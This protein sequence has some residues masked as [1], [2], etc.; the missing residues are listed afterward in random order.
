MEVT[1]RDFLIH[2]VNKNIRVATVGLILEGADEARVGV[3]EIAC[4]LVVVAHVNGVDEHIVAVGRSESVHPDI[5]V[6]KGE[7]AIG[8]FPAIPPDGKVL[9]IF[10]TVVPADADEAPV[11][12]SDRRLEVVVTTTQPRLDVAVH[13]ARSKTPG[14][15][16]IRRLPQ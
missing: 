9:V 13:L 5:S 1:I 6:G 8:R 11:V 2:L 3:G 4:Q 15:P 7:P 12:Y 16:A 14:V 10:A